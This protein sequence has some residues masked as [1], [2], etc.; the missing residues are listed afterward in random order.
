MATVDALHRFPI[1][2]LSAEPLV[3]MTLSRDTGLAHDREYAIALGTTVF[4]PAHPEP[5]DKG[6]FLMLRN[7]TALAALTTQLDPATKILRI[8]RNREPVFQANL[9]TDSGREETEGFF[10]DYL[11]EETRGRPRLVWAKDHKFTD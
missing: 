4:D 10:A 6:F 2:G 3:E 7:N 8:R 9:S 5:L 1:K 11:G